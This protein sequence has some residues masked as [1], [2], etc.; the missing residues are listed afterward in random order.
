MTL[1]PLGFVG[2]AT[3]TAGYQLITNTFIPKMIGSGKASLV[4][5]G[6]LLATVCGLVMVALV[7]IFIE[8]AGKW[9][10]HWRV[11]EATIVA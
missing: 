2:T 5:Q 6:Y 4:F 9:L 1:L 3:E 8:A 7:A 11:R 10:K